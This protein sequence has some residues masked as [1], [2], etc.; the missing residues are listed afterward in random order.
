MWAWVRKLA[1]P[2]RRKLI[3]SAVFAAVNSA[4]IMPASA[5]GATIVVDVKSGQVLS[6]DNAFQRWY[7]AS[8]TKIMTAYVAF[9]A[10]KAGQL[11]LKSPI[12]MSRHAAKE[13]PSKMGYKP[14]SQMTLD[15]A[16]KMLI[17]KSANDVAMAI[18]ESVAGS[19]SAFARRM[20]AEAKRLGMAGT[21]FVNPN[22]LHN[23]RQHSTARDLAILSAAV[24]REFPEYDHYF[25]LEGITAGKKTLRSHNVLLGRYGGADGMKT[26][27]IC[28]SG[29]NLVG[30]ATRNG[31]T[32]VS[33]VLGAKSQEERAEAAAKLLSEGFKKR[34]SALPKI[35]AMTAYGSSRNKAP[36]M[37][38]V[39]C[40]KKARAARWNERDSNGRLIIRSRYLK[41]MSGKPKTVPVG[42]G[43]ADGP[44]PEIFANV[45]VPTPRPPLEAQK[46][47]LKPPLEDGIVKNAGIPVPTPRP[48]L[49]R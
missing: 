8:L 4:Q 14:G 38:P 23:P 37:R 41:P 45:P 26:G 46:L 1:L 47:A 39:I 16:L 29:F 15:N 7:P 21:N 49:I 40:T 12:R 42:L 5:V 2:S 9:R 44:A 30:S 19:E 13:P 11:T 3:A 48:S 6:H 20:N 33:V 18:A 36:N 22:G 10:V 43:G 25:G 31:R 35:S 32:L 24:R 34:G 27:F 17:V 28:A